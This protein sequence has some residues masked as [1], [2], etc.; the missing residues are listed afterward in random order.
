MNKKPFIS[1]R[2]QDIVVLL[3][4]VVEEN[5][6][7]NQISLAKSLVM[8]QSEVSESLSRS[9]YARLLFDK[10]YKVAKQAFI[11]LLKYGVPYIYP[12]QP[13]A[14]VRGIPTAHS[15]LPLANHI[16]SSEHY[17]WPY[18]KGH[19]RGHSIQPFYKSVVQAVEFDPKLYELLALVDALRVG[20]ARERNLALELLRERIL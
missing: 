5:Q 6:S 14:V 10:D 13:G 9:R 17:I 8:S 12:Q 7:W 11:D 2:P 19:M 3:K 1:M 4:L 20:R 15:A 16:Q 18:A